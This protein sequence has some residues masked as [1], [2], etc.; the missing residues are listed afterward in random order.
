MLENQGLLGYRLLRSYR[1][2]HPA[3]SVSP[4][5]QRPS[6]G[7]FRLWLAGWLC[8]TLSSLCELGLIVRDCT[9]LLV[10]ARPRARQP[11]LFFLLSVMQYTAPLRRASLAALAADRLSSRPCTT[12]NEASVQ[13]FGFVQLGDSGDRVDRAVCGPVGCLWRSA[14]T[15]KGHGARLLGRSLLHRRVAR[16]RSAV[17]APELIVLDARGVRSH[18]VRH[19]RSGHGRSDAGAGAHSQ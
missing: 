1:V 11:L 17:V 14:D 10:G 19:D 15:H 7:Y 18:V 12:S 3:G 2:Y 9:D 13:P 16:H 5:P 6:S 8:L 4:F